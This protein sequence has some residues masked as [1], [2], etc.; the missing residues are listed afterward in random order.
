MI[1]FCSRSMSIEECWDEYIAKESVFGRLQLA[2]LLSV[3][4]VIISCLVVYAFD[5]SPIIRG[6][7]ARKAYWISLIFQIFFVSLLTIYVADATCFSVAFIEDILRSQTRWPSDVK[8]EF[9]GKT[10]E[11]LA[12]DKDAIESNVILDKLIDV[13]FIEKRTE[14]L[15]P[16]VYA[17]FFVIALTIIGRGNFISPAPLGSMGII[18]EGL[19]LGCIVSCASVLTAMAEKAREALLADLGNEIVRSGQ[20]RKDEVWSTQQLKDLTEWVQ[21]MHNGAFSPLL[22]QPVVRGL[23]LPI[24]GFALNLLNQASWLRSLF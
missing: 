7:V 9:A 18:G 23:V 1:G 11:K 20:P 19:A 24:A 21:S 16:L 15:L 4:I 13:V 17:P 22:E 5:D 2:C 8:R 6:E 10:N 12:A 14:C 3:G